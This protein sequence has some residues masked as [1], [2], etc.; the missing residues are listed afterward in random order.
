MHTG[1]TFAPQHGGLEVGVA[2]GVLDKMVAAHEPLVAQGTQEALLA[3]V[4][5]G[6]ASQL[7]RTGKLLVTVRP[8]AGERPLACM[9]SDVRFQMR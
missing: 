7:V 5:A 3:G 9:C 1:R 2:A 4:S 6:V 8:G